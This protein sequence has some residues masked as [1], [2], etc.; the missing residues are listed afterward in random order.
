MADAI[1]DTLPDEAY[2]ALELQAS[3]H[4]VSVETEVRTILVDVLQS[5]KASSHLVGLSLRD[6]LAMT[7]EEHDFEF[8][9]PINRELPRIPDFS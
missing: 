2:R 1:L 9:P 3:S 4:G 6:A 7:G 5:K 8:N